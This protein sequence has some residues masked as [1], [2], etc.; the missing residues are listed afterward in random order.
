MYKCRD[1]CI[2]D[3]K[4]TGSEEK[5]NA[6]KYKMG[7]TCVIA[8]LDVLFWPAKEEEDNVEKVGDGTLL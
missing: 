8:P 5:L 3:A 7:R 2:G 6:A 1:G 4:T